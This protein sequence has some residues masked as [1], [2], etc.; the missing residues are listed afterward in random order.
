MR[1]YSQRLAYGH[2]LPSRGTS[3]L[4]RESMGERVSSLPT[5]RSTPELEI[6]MDLRD[7]RAFSPPRP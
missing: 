7:L 5:F 6:P 4:A 1:Y 2:G 3:A